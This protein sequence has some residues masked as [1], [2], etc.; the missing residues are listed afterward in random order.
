[1]MRMLEAWTEAKGQEI[2]GA[3]SWRD[4]A[5][6]MTRLLELLRRPLVLWG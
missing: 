3:W 4:F 6:Q 5:P 1:M 2:A